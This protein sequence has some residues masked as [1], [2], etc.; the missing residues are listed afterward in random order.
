[1]QVNNIPNRTFVFNY[2]T[3]IKSQSQ[4]SGKY[5]LVF[6]PLSSY[7]SDFV[8]S[9]SDRNATNKLIK[10]NARYLFFITH[11]YVRIYLIQ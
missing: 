8:D 1:M 3:G 6:D 4:V 7:V 11:T 9:S 5:D 10:I 2:P